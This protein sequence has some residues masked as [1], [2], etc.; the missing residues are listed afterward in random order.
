MAVLSRITRSNSI[1]I[2]VQEDHGFDS[3]WEYKDF[4]SSEPP[5][6]LIEKAYFPVF[7]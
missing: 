1:V 5:V 7:C 4:F 3:C 6:S 2:T